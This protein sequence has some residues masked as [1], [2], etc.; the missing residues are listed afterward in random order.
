MQSP[1]FLALRSLLYPRDHLPQNCSWDLQCLL[2]PVGTIRNMVRRKMTAGNRAWFWKTISLAGVRSCSTCLPCFQSC[3]S[4]R[5]LLFLL[6]ILSDR[7]FLV[8]SGAS[9]S[10]FPGP[11]S[12]SP[13]PLHHGL[14]FLHIACPPVRLSLCPVHDHQPSQW[15]QSL[16]SN[17]LFSG[18]CPPFIL[19]LWFLLLYVIS[20]SLL[21]F[22][23]SLSSGCTSISEALVL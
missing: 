1:P 17:P 8:D 3:T 16:F 6:D 20:C 19:D 13:W 5:S 15:S 23:W 14:W 11:K 4:S 10:V 7:E 21:Y 22:T 9:V 12:A 2:D 18:M